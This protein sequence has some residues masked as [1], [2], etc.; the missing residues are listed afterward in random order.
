MTFLRIV[1]AIGL[2]VRATI[3]GQ[4]LD[5]L[6]REKSGAHFSADFPLALVARRTDICTQALQS[7]P[8]RGRN[9][10]AA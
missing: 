1:V 10:P 8:A 9:V 7:W 2:A 5:V 6:S 4:R 3:P